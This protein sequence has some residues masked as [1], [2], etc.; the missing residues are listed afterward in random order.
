[1]R[2]YLLLFVLALFAFCIKSWAA[3]W[4]D[5]V[6]GLQDGIL[7]SNLEW[8]LSDNTGTLTIKG[9]G[10]MFN[11]ESG[12][13]PW[14]QYREDI[15]KV[16]IYNNV[17]TI[18]NL[19]FEG[20]KNM[21]TVEFYNTSNSSYLQTI[22]Q[23]AFYNCT[24]LGSLDL[25]KAKLTSLDYVAFGNCSSLTS[26]TLPTTLQTIGEAAFSGCTNLTSINISSLSNL[27]TIGNY[28]CPVKLKTA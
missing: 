4:G 26:I 10:A 14:Y 21:T 18:G 19:A 28:C 13:A 20:C 7:S 6:C 3:D 12:K 27:T 5:G 16:V 11:Y 22:G 8:K 24:A 2:K 23:G 17:T 1:M 15:K 9:S 25:S